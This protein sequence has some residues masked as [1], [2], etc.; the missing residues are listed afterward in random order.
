MSEIV[1]RSIRGICDAQREYEKWSGF[2][3][4]AAPEYLVATSIAR[5]I[6]GLAGVGFV[7]LEKNLTEALE[8]AGGSWRGRR[9]VSLPRQGRF[10]IVVWTRAAQPRVVLE[11][12]ADVAGY[13]N[14]ARDVG[15]ICSAIGKTN[16]LHRGLVAYY[17]SL[18]DGLRK[19]ARTRVIERAERIAAAAHNDV[20][21]RGRGFFQRRPGKLY[22]QGDR[23]WKPEILEI[24][25]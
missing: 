2:A 13:S 23:A 3:L 12:K 1:D 16:D 5:S 25:Q 17:V 19:P 4:W 8:E 21:A 7:T 24:G 15:R 9:N 20:N 14:V 11:V 10:D 6:H 22:E 18:G